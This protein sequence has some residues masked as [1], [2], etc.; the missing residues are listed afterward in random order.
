MPTDVPPRRSKPAR[1]RA[2][3]PLRILITAGPTREYIDSVRY[4]SNDS[5]GA[6]GFALAAA[7]AARGH[8]VT[9]IHG[10]VSLAAA[11]GVHAVSVISAAEMLAACRKAWPARDVL[12]MAAAVADYR[13]AMRLDSKRKKSSRDFVLKLRPTVDILAD[14]SRRRQPTQRVIGFALE[15][16]NARRN[17][18]SKLRRKNLD[19][20][21][22]NSPAAIG[23]ARSSVEILVCGGRWRSLPNAPKGQ[24]ARRLIRLAE[25][26]ATVRARSQR[27]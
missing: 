13:P 15:D 16:R 24:T 25:E 21:V 9:L 23:R 10:P 17:A 4:L 20:I 2:G 26:L 5:S 6:M 11:R 8:R 18:E 12:I 27:T 7:A 19:A 22:L 1:R 14:L 3:A